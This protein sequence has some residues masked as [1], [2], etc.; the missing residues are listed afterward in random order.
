MQCGRCPHAG[1]LQCVR[2]H[3]R[4]VVILGTRSLSKSQVS[5]A[6]SAGQGLL[7][8]GPVHALRHTLIACQP[9]DAPMHAAT[10]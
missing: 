3:R 7:A 2:L 1:W 4:S 8:G 5:V 6:H 9:L 10:G